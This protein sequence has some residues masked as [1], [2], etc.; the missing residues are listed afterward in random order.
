MYTHLLDKVGCWGGWDSVCL[1]WL[2]GGILEYLWGVQW[3]EVLDYTHHFQTPQEVDTASRLLNTSKPVS[4]HVDHWFGPG[5]QQILFIPKTLCTYCW[6][7]L[8]L[9][10][11]VMHVFVV[12]PLM[13]FLFVCLLGF[14]RC[15]FFKLNCTSY[16]EWIV[17]CYI[18]IYL[19]MCVLLVGQLS[20][21]SCGVC[22]CAD[23]N[24][25]PVVPFVCWFLYTSLLFS[26]SENY[27]NTSNRISVSRHACDIDL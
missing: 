24:Y 2:S 20:L 11:I 18:G 27:Q 7:S 22:E 3:A 17:G 23:Y 15:C 26:E 14:C 13:Y 19:V 9:L 21:L 10:N 1:E 12:L 4:A 8:L 16:L 6:Y 5:V 25:R